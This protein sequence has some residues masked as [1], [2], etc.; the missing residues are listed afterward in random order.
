MFRLALINP[1]T[2]ARHTEAM[3]AVARETL[4]NGCDVTAVSP[5][6]GPTSIESEADSVVAA[7][8]VAE[9]VR[10]LPAHDGYLVACFGDPGLDAARELTEAPV[11]GIGEAAFRAAATVA[12]RF[13]VITTLPR[14]VPELEDAL[15]RQGMRSRCV[16]VEPLGIPVA[17]QGGH[18]AGTTAAI[19]EAG[20]RA[21]AR[22][23]AEALVLAC[24]GMA[25]VARTVASEVGVPVCD[26]VAFGAMTAYG[27]WRCGLRTSKSGAYGWPEAIAYSGMPG[28][29]GAR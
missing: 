27:L 9:L 15:E 26:G 14:S 20:R 7:A 5:E 8:A 22:D 25:D 19:V 16:A 2:D 28:N 10:E 1:N 29:G 18:N 12:R 4:P 21:V 23:R 3:G 13:A 17:D 24:G 11:V 6:R